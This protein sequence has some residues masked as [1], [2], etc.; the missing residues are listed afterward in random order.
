MHKL[1][2]ILQLNTANPREVRLSLR[3][4]FQSLLSPPSRTNRSYVLS[5]SRLRRPRSHD[6]TKVPA[7]AQVYA[8]RN[9][10][11]ESFVSPQNRTWLKMDV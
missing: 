1:T 11:C 6:G 8:R 3:K 10:D 5:F 2:E 9:G 7:Y 4:S